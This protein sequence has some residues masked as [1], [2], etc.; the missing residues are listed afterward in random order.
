L[1]HLDALGGLGRW[2][3]LKEL[4]LSEQS[5]LDPDLAALADWLN[6]VTLALRSAK[7]SA[8]IKERL[9]SM[10]REQK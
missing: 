3:E 10:V 7:A 1:R 4:L 5:G 8:A 6:E 2:S 9:M